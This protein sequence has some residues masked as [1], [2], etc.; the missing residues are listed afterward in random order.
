MVLNKTEITC[1]EEC[2]C[3]PQ[4]DHQEK[5]WKRNDEEYKY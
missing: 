2:N 4:V 5:T 3:N 1:V